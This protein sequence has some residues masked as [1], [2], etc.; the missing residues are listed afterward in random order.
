M[1]PEEVKADIA[2]KL[3]VGVEGERDQ[4]TPE[5]IKAARKSLG[6]SQRAFAEILLLGNGGEE[7]VRR[8]EDGETLMSSPDQV[9]LYCLLSFGYTA[10]EVERRERR[11][12]ASLAA[13]PKDAIPVGACIPRPGVRGVMGIIKTPANPDPK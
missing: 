7:Q 13:R 9:N 11:Y 12:Y 5:D 6:L 3:H 10:D 2:E 4:A 8:W 1:T